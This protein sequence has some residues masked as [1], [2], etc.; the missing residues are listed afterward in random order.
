[1]KNETNKEKYHKK[2][3]TKKPTLKGNKEK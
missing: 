3:K 2:A 1:M